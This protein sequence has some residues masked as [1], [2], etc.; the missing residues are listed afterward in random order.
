LRDLTKPNAH[1]PATHGILC[2]SVA[3]PFATTALQPWPVQVS[4]SQW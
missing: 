1:L 3:T 2:A 4:S